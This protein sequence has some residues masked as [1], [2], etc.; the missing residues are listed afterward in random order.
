MRVSVE[1][2]RFLQSI[3]FN[4]CSFQYLIIDKILRLQRLWTFYPFCLELVFLKYILHH[5][6]QVSTWLSSMDILAKIIFFHPSSIRSLYP[7]RLFFFGNHP[8]Y[9][10]WFPVFKKFLNFSCPP[11]PWHYIVFMFNQKRTR[12]LIGVQ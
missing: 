4:L 3:I 5:L 8:P 6:I 2:L 10:I 1:L 7:Y 9:Y 11:L 12:H